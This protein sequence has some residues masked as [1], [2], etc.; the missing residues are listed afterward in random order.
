MKEASF[1]EIITISIFRPYTHVA[2]D[3][4]PSHIYENSGNG[5]SGEINLNSAVSVIT[6]DKEDRSDPI[7][8]YPS[9]CSN[10]LDSVGNDV[11][12]TS[13]VHSAN[14]LSG[15]SGFGEDTALN[16]CFSYDDDKQAGEDVA[17]DSSSSPPL[18]ELTK[19]YSEIGQLSL[20]SDVRVDIMRPFNAL[21]DNV[22]ESD[23][24]SSTKQATMTE[25]S[26]NAMDMLDGT[27]KACSLEESSTPHQSKDD[28]ESTPLL[29]LHE[30]FD[31]AASTQF[32]TSISLD[33]PLNYGSLNDND[34]NVKEDD[35]E[36]ISSIIGASQQSNQ[37]QPILNMNQ[38]NNNRIMPTT[39]NLT[40]L[41]AQ[42]MVIDDIEQGPRHSQYPSQART[43]HN[44]GPPTELYIPQNILEKNDDRSE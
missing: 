43:T 42:D 22:M 7:L 3:L 27:R 36:V 31:T 25:G 34:K 29:P 11:F 30:R 6:G 23:Y 41:V 26:N 33:M 17:D 14:D 15:F 28:I 10:A 12:L 18:Q 24:S 2:F 44:D 13:A 20:K 5:K 35:D 4:D 16:S 8:S 32:D 9:T 40:M 39:R 38:R 37:I 1:V 21:G 19:D